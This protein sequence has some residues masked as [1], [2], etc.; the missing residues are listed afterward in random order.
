MKGFFAWF[1]NSTKMKRWLM[2]ILAGIVLLCYGIAQILVKNE[3]T[4][5]QL[6]DRK[7]VV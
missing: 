1:K 7:S 6:G 3:M 5:L 2:M 4:I